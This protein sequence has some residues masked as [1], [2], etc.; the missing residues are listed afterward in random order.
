M[1][2]NNENFTA[3]V[4]KFVTIRSYLYWA[5]SRKILDININYPWNIQ[6]FNTIKMQ[7]FDRFGRKSSS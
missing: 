2:F 1:F 5:H 6:L 7:P 3:I 4:L